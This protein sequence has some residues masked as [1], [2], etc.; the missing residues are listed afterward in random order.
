M[1]AAITINGHRVECVPGASIFE[2]AGQAGV[3]VPT[4][5]AAQGK[6]KECV[7]E[8]TAGMEWLS[9][10]KRYEQ[11]LDVKGTAFRLSC[12]SRVIADE[13]EIQ[14]Q[15]MR[16]GQM[17]IERHALDLP[18]SHQKMPL[19]PAVTREGPD[20]VLIDGVEVARS[21]DHIYG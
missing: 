2:V 7:V 9:P 19:E 18:V 4:S 6:C 3:R 21:T 1:S 16:R 8:V 20:R 14:C 10:P 12:Q 11:H 13:G 5:C 17:R 15:T